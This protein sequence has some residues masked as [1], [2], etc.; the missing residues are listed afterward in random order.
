MRVRREAFVTLRV[1]G[2]W[3]GRRSP[4]VAAGRVS[5]LNSDRSAEQSSAQRP[6]VVDQTGGRAGPRRAVQG[7]AGEGTAGQGRGEERMAGQCRGGQG[8]A[9]QGSAGLGSG[10]LGRAGQAG[11]VHG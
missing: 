2:S 1:V 3:P 8:W 5:M 4:L 11:V 9:G 7:G 10:G 6:H